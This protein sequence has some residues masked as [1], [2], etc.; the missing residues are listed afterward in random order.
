MGGGDVHEHMIDAH[1]TRACRAHSTRACRTDVT[2][3]MRMYALSQRTFTVTGIATVTVDLQWLHSCCS[4][5]AS[6]HDRVTLHLIEAGAN[7]EEQSYYG[8]RT[9]ETMNAHARTHSCY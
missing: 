4:T 9:A 1:S 7:L 2:H 5:D 8:R 3:L 6:G